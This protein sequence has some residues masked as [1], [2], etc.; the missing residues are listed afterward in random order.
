[1]YFSVICHLTVGENFQGFSGFNALGWSLISA[2]DF[3]GVPSSRYV[4]GMRLVEPTLKA[5]LESERRGLRAKS[6]LWP[7]SFLA[8]TVKTG[9]KYRNVSYK[10]FKT[11]RPFWERVGPPILSLESVDYFTTSVSGWRKK[12]PLWA[13]RQGDFDGEADWSGVVK[14]FI[15]CKWVMWW[16]C[17]YFQR[18]LKWRA[19]FFKFLLFVNDIFSL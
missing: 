5:R 11:C 15:V 17:S 18:R 19:M 7:W 14:T 10:I 1:M 12:E 16:P 9:A 6:D 4:D 3:T 8:E 2:S 13:K